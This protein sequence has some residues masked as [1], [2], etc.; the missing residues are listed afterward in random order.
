L[1]SRP[2]KPKHVIELEYEYAVFQTTRI[3]T[4]TLSYI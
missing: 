1:T 4:R 3:A 2:A